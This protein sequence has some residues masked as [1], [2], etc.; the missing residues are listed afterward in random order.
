MSKGFGC[1]GFTAAVVTGLVIGLIAL[2][3]VGWHW[4][5]TRVLANE[6][7]TVYA[8][9]WTKLDEAA[10]ATK[11]A[12]L[13]LLMKQNM[14]GEQ[15]VVLNS[16]E[17]GRVLGEYFTR[18]GED[19]RAA[20]S[21]GDTATGV[22]FSRQVLEGKYLNGELRA[23]IKAK[24]GDFQVKVYSLRTGGVKWRKWWLPLFCHVIEGEL[25]TQSLFE[26]MPLR[27]TDYNSGK[28]QVKLTLKV[29]KQ[30]KKRKDKST[31]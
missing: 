3:V 2:L 30:K 27:I 9:K 12:P 18:R 25:E 23:D 7:E 16:G 24:S 20:V 10:L 15:K 11:L 28:D 8:Q 4:V 17:A 13:A 21:L 19:C 29:V 1:I 6:P 22:T 14:E 31:P 26:D 5:N